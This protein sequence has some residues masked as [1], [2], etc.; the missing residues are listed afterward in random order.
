MYYI[1]KIIN[2]FGLGKGGLDQFVRRIS[3]CNLLD[4]QWDSNRNTI[5]ST[6][7]SLALLV[8]DFS[9]LEKSTI[10]PL[11]L[12]LV[13]SDMEYMIYLWAPHFKRD[14]SRHLKKDW[15][16]LK[17]YQGCGRRPRVCR[18]FPPPQSLSILIDWLIILVTLESDAAKNSVGSTKTCSLDFFSFLF[19]SNF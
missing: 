5:L 12:S 1:I 15:R 3:V 6:L 14:T 2:R 13:R 11:Y 4:Q 9:L 19:T 16:R 18:A 8:L 10:F 17:Y 7:F